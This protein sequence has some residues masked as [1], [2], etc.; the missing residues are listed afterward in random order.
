MKSATD[1]PHERHQVEGGA[2]RAIHADRHGLAKKMGAQVPSLAL[3]ITSLLVL[4]GCE[5]IKGIFKAGVGVG[6]ISVVVVMVVI[7]GIVAMVRK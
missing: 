2:P 4:D 7:G 6:V 5:V 3:M 1:R